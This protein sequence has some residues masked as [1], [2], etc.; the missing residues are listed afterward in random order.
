MW[1]PGARNAGRI[2]RRRASRESGWRRS[3]HPSRQHCISAGAQPR[4]QHSDHHRYGGSRTK[5]RIGGGQHS[6]GHSKKHSD[7]T[8]RTTDYSTA[9]AEA[10][11]K[12]IERELMARAKSRE[13]KTFADK[14]V[15]VT[16]YLNPTLK[17][18]LY[19]EAKAQGRPVY[20]VLEDILKEH[21]GME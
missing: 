4:N 12:E 5:H 9:E 18:L 20:L 2:V 6:R 7:G 3:G 15:K 10:H 14:T 16:L 8:A 21:F 17:K 13:K 19:L 11:A 1:P